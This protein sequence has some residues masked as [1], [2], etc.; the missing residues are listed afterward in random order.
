MEQVFMVILAVF[1]AHCLGDFP[2]QG[3]YLA[4]KKSE[5]AYLLICHSVIVSG[6]V[7]FT[8][9]GLSILDLIARIDLHTGCS[10]MVILLVTHCMIDLIKITFNKIYHAKFPEDRS[11]NSGYYI[12][13]MDQALHI[14]VY[15][16][17]LIRF[18]F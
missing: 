3:T 15:A 6:C 14:I 1:I 11:G 18:C 9:W 12:L 13:Y 7:M 16:F 5:S 8:I 10:I 4:E 2:L 17:I